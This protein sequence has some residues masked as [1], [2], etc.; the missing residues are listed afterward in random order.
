[1]QSKCSDQ[2]K[3]GKEGSLNFFFKKVYWVAKISLRHDIIRTLLLEG[4]LS[5]LCQSID[6]KETKYNI[7]HC[8]R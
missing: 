8:K 1:M 7:V 2:V 6:K 4:S 5:I 3:T